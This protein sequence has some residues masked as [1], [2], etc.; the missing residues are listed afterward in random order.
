[1]TK[2]EKLITR[3]KDNP[4]SLRYEEIRIIL[5][6]AWFEEI[7][8]K[9]SHMKFKKKWLSTDIILPLHNNDC[10]DFYKKQTHKKLY[11]YNLI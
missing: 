6:D 8:A 1:M 7:N 10:K 3:F 9:W 2:K 5:L 11:S 4:A